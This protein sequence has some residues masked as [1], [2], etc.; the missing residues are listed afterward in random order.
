MTAEQ[1]LERGVAELGLALPQG[2]PGRFM[3]YIALLGKWNRT[4]NLTAIH[5]PI[6]MVTHHL[7][8]S[9]A[10]VPHL[11]A[12]AG[13]NLA[14]VG[15]GAG[16]PGIAL[17]IAQPQ[18]RV[19]VNDSREKKSAFLR[20]VTIELKLRNVEVH[21]GRVEQWMPTNKFALVISRAFAQLGEFRALCAHLVAPDGFL[22]AMTAAA[23]QACDCRTIELKVPMLQARRH[24]VLCPAQL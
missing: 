2:A 10:V 6:E 7:L 5:D 1:A 13:A 8:D 11:P 24:L 9:L 23:A 15:S 22:A 12:P 17:A 4:Y 16:L 14:D 21:H 19:T 3:D 18:W 20:Q